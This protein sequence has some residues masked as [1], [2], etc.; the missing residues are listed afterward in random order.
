MIAAI[1]AVGLLIDTLLIRTLLMP[2]LV[3]LLGRRA[4]WES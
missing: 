1:M 2:A 4:G 3:S